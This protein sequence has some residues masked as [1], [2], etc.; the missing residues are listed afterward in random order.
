MYAGTND[1]L[2]LYNV[3]GEEYINENKIF[4]KFQC[5]EKIKIEEKIES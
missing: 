1:T 2:I 4:I 5:S 3:M